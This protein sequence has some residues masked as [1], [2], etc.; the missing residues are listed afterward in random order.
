M[1]LYENVCRWSVNNLECTIFLPIGHTHCYP[2]A[3]MHRV[4]TFDFISNWTMADAAR[5]TKGLGGRKPRKDLW[6]YF[7]FN[8]TERRTECIVEG[9]GGKC[10]FKLG[11]K[12][13][14]NL[15]RHLKAHHP[16]IF[17]KIPEILTP[18]EK[19]GGPKNDRSQSSIPAAFAAGSKYK[20]DSQ[21]QHAKEQ[22]I[23]LWIGRTGLPACTVEDEDFILMM[24]TFDKRLTI[25]KR[26]K[27]N[28]LVDKIYDGEKQKFKERLATAHKITIGLD[29]WTK[30]GLTASFLAISACFFCTVENKAQHI[31]LRLD[32]LPHPHTAECI[33]T[34]VDQCTEDWGIPQHKILTVITDNGSNM[35]AA[36]KAN[37][38]DELSSSEDES[39]DV[40]D[41]EDPEVIG[42]DQRF[43]AI[44]R[45]PCVVHTLQLVVN[46]IQKDASINRLL[47]KVRLLVKLFRKSSVATQRLLQDSV[48]QVADEMSWD[49]LLPTVTSYWN[50]AAARPDRLRALVYHIRAHHQSGGVLPN[51]NSLAAPTPGAKLGGGSQSKGVQKTESSGKPCSQPELHA[52]HRSG[53]KRMFPRRRQPSPKQRCVD[54]GA[55]TSPQHMP[56]RIS[57]IVR[58]QNESSGKPRSQQELHASHRSG[59]KRT[60]PRRRQ[61]SPKQRCVDE[62]AHTSPQHTPVHIDMNVNLQPKRAQSPFEKTS[63]WGTRSTLLR[64]MTAVEAVTG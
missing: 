22:A 27:I 52:F 40:S 43:G 18:K 11:G 14:T 28:N 63:P 33:K 57:M 60:F 36:F 13:T 3:L 31:L 30:K 29:I 16:D 47:G 50:Q 37:E 41:T 59:V 48:V 10:G 34:H 9:D 55:H 17:S 62:G 2:T 7:V 32:Q 58:P 25:P 51:G 4:L 1:R 45:T 23:A 38:P 42:Q 5:F 56:A 26:T 24:E 44:D 64:C 15:K 21:E 8:P 54:E 53:V 39:I 46:M 12:N 20:T 19:P 6:T 35:I 61:L 49:Y